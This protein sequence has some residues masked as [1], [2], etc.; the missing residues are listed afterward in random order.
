MLEG[1]IP[2]TRKVLAKAGLKLSDIDLFEVN[3][4]FAS[5]VLAWL[6]EVGAD[7][8]KTNYNGGAVAIGHP[9]GS[10][11]ARLITTLLNELDRQKARY[12][13]VTMCIGHGMG[14]GTVIQR[15]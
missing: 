13:L 2:A 7:P 8:E 11:G 3:E 6:K 14:T 9:L 5:V 10:T 4:A 12:G 1:P 15:L